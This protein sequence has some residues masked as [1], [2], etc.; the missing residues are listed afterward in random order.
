MWKGPVLC[1][2]G[3]GRKQEVLDKE[4]GEVGGGD[5]T[6]NI[7]IAQDKA[8]TVYPELQENNMGTV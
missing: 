6:E 3:R 1:G 2:I 4:I 8:F 7:F 5:G